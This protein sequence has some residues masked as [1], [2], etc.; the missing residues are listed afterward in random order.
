ML[1]ATSPP[2]STSPLLTLLPQLLL[3]P[4]RRWAR[5]QLHSQPH[6]WDEK[7]KHGPHPRRALPYGVIHLPSSLLSSMTYLVTC[8]T[9]VADAFSAAP[10]PVTVILDSTSGSEL[11]YASIA[12]Y[13][14]LHDNGPPPP[15]STPYLHSRSAKPQ[16]RIRLL[17]L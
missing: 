9:D 6:R 2:C 3:S 14:L 7:Q 10:G 12:D 15:A 5:G 4:T 8:T 13:P 11:R 16:H 1:V 17:Q